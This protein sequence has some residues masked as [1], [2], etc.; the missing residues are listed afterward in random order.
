MYE[1]DLF[2]YEMLCI[3][4]LREFIPIMITPHA[5]TQQGLSNAYAFRVCMSVSV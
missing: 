1:S 5:D 4:Q 2:L 3:M